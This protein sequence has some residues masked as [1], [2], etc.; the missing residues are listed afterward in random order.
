MCVMTEHRNPPAD[1]VSD[2]KK[3][4]SS[5]RLCKG[6]SGRKLHGVIIFP[7]E[8]FAVHFNRNMI[9]VLFACC[10]AEQRVVWIRQ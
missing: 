4:N 9:S 7:F 10:L 6:Q 3:N 8:E 5:A 2:L 1:V